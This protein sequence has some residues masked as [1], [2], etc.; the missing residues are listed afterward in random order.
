MGLQDK[1][2]KKQK[3]IVWV[4]GTPNYFNELIDAEIEKKEWID[5][6][7]NDVIIEIVKDN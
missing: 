1:A 6:G 7:Y 2:I 3:Y 4:G 5:Q